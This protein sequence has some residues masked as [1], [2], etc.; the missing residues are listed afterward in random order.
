MN[1]DSTY[2]RMV[3]IA[4]GA[5]LGAVYGLISQLINRILLL[6]ISFY[7]PPAGPVGNILIWASIG[8][9]LGL[10]TAWPR[11]SIHGALLGAVASVFV[12]TILTMLTGQRGSETLLGKLLGVAFLILPML[13]FFVP[14]VAV[15][16]WA[17][18]GVVEA[19]I[20][21]ANWQVAFRRPL[22]LGAVVVVVGGL[23]LLPGYA[24][25]M[26]MHANNLII[27]GLQ[28]KTASELPPALQT[29]RVGAFLEYAQPPYTLQWDKNNLTR[30]AIPRPLS[31]RPTQE[32]VVIARFSNGWALVCL[33]MYS[34]A[35][36]ICKGFE[37]EEEFQIP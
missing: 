9:F 18:N 10:A 29:P 11:E 13:G 27:T 3:G 31:D 23:S 12:L 15:Q 17:V 32:S 37:R 7:Q 34:D 28:A 25:S 5:S 19:H 6:D 22:L 35:E 4:L 2:R 8:A 26:L 33:Y 14:L 21:R 20:D 1:G 24:R 36:P 16:R 30:F